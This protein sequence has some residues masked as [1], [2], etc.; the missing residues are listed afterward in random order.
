MADLAGRCHGCGHHRDESMA[1]D[2][3]G[4]PLHDYEARSDVCYACEASDIEKRRIAHDG[5]EDAM[6]GRIF[7]TVRE[8]DEVRPEG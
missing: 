6:A 8:T 4:R 2:E 1:K 7:Y 5:G 3:H